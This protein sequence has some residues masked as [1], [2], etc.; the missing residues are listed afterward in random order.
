MSW[1]ADRVFNNVD[2]FIQWLDGDFGEYIS[3][4]ISENHVHHTWKPNHSNYPKYTT[5]QLHKNMR[6]FH[7]NTSGWDDIAQ[8]I[9]IGKNGDIVTGRDIRKIPISAKN[10]NG[11][12][13]WHPFAYE[14]LGNFDIGNDKLAG[15]QLE[16]AIKISR[17]FHKKG[18]AVK[19]HRE[20]LLNGKQPKSCPGTG[21]D[22]GWFMGLVNQQKAPAPQPS[23][24][25]IE[26]KFCMNN[27]VIMKVRA[28]GAGDIRRAPDHN[29]GFVRNTVD[30]EVFDVYGI[31]NDWHA[32]GQDNWIDGN[33]G[34]NLHWIDNPNLKQS[35]PTSSPH[36]E[37]LIGRI[38]VKDSVSTLN[39]RNGNSFTA[40]ISRTTTKKDKHL[41]FEK[42]NGM[43]RITESGDWITA[44]SQYVSVD[45]GC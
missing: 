45:W 13:N 42:K 16:S 2:E 37:K 8:N 27:T 44:N 34:K 23:K 21:I 3:K 24:N 30:G 38:T 19:F 25:P 18:K 41:V 9:T 7:V 33:G 4:H 1:I 11:T 14:M 35:K 10:Y 43:Y 32:V 26:P 36:K 5:L 31:E 39:I 20:L 28:I 22:K 29:A 17:Y 6:S 12:T 15:N 40:A